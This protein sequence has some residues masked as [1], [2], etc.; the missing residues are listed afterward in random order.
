[1]KQSATFQGAVAFRFEGDSARSPLS[2]AADA[3]D[4]VFGGVDRW[5]ALVKDGALVTVQWEGGERHMVVIGGHLYP[6]SLQ[7]R[8]NGSSSG[9]TNG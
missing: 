4:A 6:A 3:L 8:A 2:F 9:S 1:M 5:R 7:A